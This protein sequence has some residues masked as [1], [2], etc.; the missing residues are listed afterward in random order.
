M[1]PARRPPLDGGRRRR[2]VRHRPRAPQ[3]VRIRA[4][5]AGPD[6]RLEMDGRT[7]IVV[8]RPDAGSR[9]ARTWIWGQACSALDA[10]DA[11]ARWMSEAIDKPVRLVAMDGRAKRRPDPDCTLPEDEVSFA[12]CY[13]VLAI[14]QGSLDDLNT[15]NPG[16]GVDAPVP[17][18]L[19][20]RRRRTVRG[21]RLAAHPHRPGGVRRGGELRAVRA[22][23]GRSRT[24]GSRTRGASRCA[25]SP[26]IA[27]A[28]PAGCSWARTWC[29]AA[30]VRCGSAIAWWCWNPRGMAEQDDPNE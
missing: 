28:P 22:A 15:R 25:P 11:A 4:G 24:P 18:Q 7:P 19:H 26:A 13:P 9:P 20:D 8:R 10:G 27:A 5:V 14:G 23:D 16:A 17:A 21:R 6:L 1:R 2:R 29:R 12:D 3:L 30:R